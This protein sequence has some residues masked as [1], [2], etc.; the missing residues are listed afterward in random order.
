MT[1]LNR[2]RPTKPAARTPTAGQLVAG[3]ALSLLVLGTAAAAAQTC[4]TKLL[5]IPKS[6]ALYVYFPTAT[7]STFPEFSPGDT[8]PIDPFTMANHDNTINTGQVRSRAFEL[9]QA[10]YCEFDVNVKL[11][12]AVPAPTETRWQVIGIGSDLSGNG[13][14]GWAQDVDTLDS[15]AQDYCRVW[16]E[17]LENYTGAELSGANSSLERWS[18]SIANLA[19]HES[20]H[21]YG[22]QHTE[23]APR[24][25]EDAAGNHFIADP[26]TGASASTIADSFNHFGDRT[27]ERLGHNIGLHVKQLGNWDFVNPNSTNADK[28]VIT[29]LSSASTLTRAWWWNGSLSPWRDPTITKRSGVTIAFRGTNYNVFDLEFSTAKAWTG[30]PNGEAPPAVKFHV[31][32]SVNESDPVIVYEA[33]LSNGGTDLPL[34]P[35]IFGYDAGITA[36][37]GFAVSFYNAQA[38][39]GGFLEISDVNV[40]FLPRMLDL[41]QMVE[42]G[43]LLTIG[44]APIT[45]FQR[46]GRGRETEGPREVEEFRTSLRGPVQVGDDPLVLP[47]AHLTDFRHLD[48]VIKEDPDCVPGQKTSQGPSFGVPGA[49]YCPQAGNVLS[50][51]PATYVYVSAKVT[52]PNA[53]QWNPA[54]SQFVDAPL[55]TRI[56]F[57]V[58]GVIPD[59]NDN[60]IDDLIDIREGTSRDGNDNGIPD[61][62]E[63][64]RWAVSAHLGLASP[65]GVASRVLDDGLSLDLGLEYEMTSQFSLLG[66]V[67]YDSLDAKGSGP[68]LEML[69]LSLN[70]RFYFTSGPVLPFAQA[71]V[72]LYDL[73]PGSTEVGYNAALGLRWDFA[74]SKALEV[75]YKRHEV[76][77]GGG[78]NLE[79]SAAQI[80][81]R[82]RL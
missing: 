71:G 74:A 82:W 23:S 70:G 47:I 10:A 25:G 5:N 6:Q 62:A 16:V 63:G 55:T 24:T 73:S 33:T 3:A 54:T 18:R 81:L 58:A 49:H 75:L 79:Y 51:F 42:G 30:G 67:G 76:Q 46:R 43:E 1:R 52:E 35:R 44:G 37:G 80:G 66:I 65:D 61:E 12:T 28:L 8:S 72:G 53:R 11:T 32:A 13:G 26:G 60:G 21:N 4:A 14:V 29:L 22:G 9:M 15:D 7:D 50:L 36:A 59:A 64:G 19:A 31:G 2:N 77:T 78:A 57:Q 41:E 17:N 20:A 40:Q 34:H 39:D 27:Y 68:D 48:E 38:A 45:P 69:H 56:F